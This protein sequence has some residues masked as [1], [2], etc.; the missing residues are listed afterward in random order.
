MWI[1]WLGSKNTFWS[2]SNKR[3]AYS[4][5]FLL[6]KHLIIFG[7]KNRVGARFTHV[8]ERFHS[9][10]A[11]GKGLCST[12]LTHVALMNE[13]PPNVQDNGNTQQY[14]D[15]DSVG[16]VL[17]YRSKLS[18]SLLKQLVHDKSIPKFWK[19]RARKT[20]HSCIRNRTMHWVL[21]ALITSQKMLNWISAK[22]FKLI[23]TSDPCFDQ[24]SLTCPLANLL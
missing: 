19:R 18:Y 1:E 5:A 16:E 12:R 4:W 13:I 10:L 2:D 9:F 22:P 23:G 17:W 8:T 20:V 3:H 21:L 14:Y 24:K 11:G 6:D 7:G 15:L